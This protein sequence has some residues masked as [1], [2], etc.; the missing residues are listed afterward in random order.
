VAKYLLE[1]G[2][3]ELPYKFVP[4]ALNQ[5]KEA[6]NKALADNR[7]EFSNIKTYGTPR[8]LTVIVENISESQSDLTKEL[9][10]PP[11]NVAF[12]KDGNLTKAGEGFAKKQGLTPQQLFKKEI[13]GIEYVCAKIDEKGK[14]VEDVL[15]ELV[16]SIVLS[17]QGSYF[18]RWGDLNIRFSRPIRWLVS[19]IDDKEAKIKIENIESTRFSRGHRFY[20]DLNIEIKNPDT[21]FDA[22]YEAK[23]IVDQD[24]RQETIVQKANEIAATVNGKVKINPELLKEVTYLLEWPVPVLGSF[25]KKYLEI[26]DDVTVTVMASHQRYF[27]VYD[28]EGKLLNNFITMANYIGDNFE[29]IK[30][31]NERVVRARLDDAI[32]FYKED[33]KKTL[34]SRIEDLKG[35]TF[36][37]GLGTVYDKVNRIREIAYFISTEMQ[38]D[39]ETIECIERTALLSKADL[40]TN[41]VFEFT[42]LQG[43]IGA[44]YAKLNGEK[45][46]VVNGIKEHYF[47]LSADGELAT[48]ITGQIVGISDKV[49]TICGVFAIGKKPTGSA[50]PL[51]LRRAALGTMLTIINK[52]LNINLS[53]VIENSVS[54]QPVKIDNKDELISEIREFIIQRLKI[55]LNDTYRYDIV[56]AAM[57]AKDPLADLNDLIERIKILTDLVNSEGYTSFHESAN[58]ISRII[59]DREYKPTPDANLFEQDVEGK[60]WNCVQDIE[61]SKLT[62]AGIIEKLKSSIPVIEEFF[63]KVLVMV[64]DE[65]IRENRVSLLANMR[66]QFLKI[67]DFSKIVE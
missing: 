46:I 5:L 20:K 4:S 14:P 32:F 25:D 62:Y 61:S 41:L 7:I 47:P 54:I 49:D 22:L 18:M 19:L 52:G 34:E 50:D 1:I 38:L 65:N 11:A 59:K 28:N 10:G 37:K 58:R 51:G 66:N 30:R 27:P 39:K 36:Q 24:K 42:E 63:D 2:T 6:F 15:K 35:I 64:E 13:G 44:D 21:Y 16:P 67:G 53:K 57:S 31:G 55:Y 3:E 26:P 48:S 9:K 45:D 60:L 43:F 17:L 29:N 56:D 23:V 8:R 33:T 40:V 12:D